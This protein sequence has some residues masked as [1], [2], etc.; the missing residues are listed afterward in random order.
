MPRRFVRWWWGLPRWIKLLKLIVILGVVLSFPAKTAYENWQYYHR[1]YD[2]YYAHFY[3]A[4]SQTHADHLAHHW[5][6]HYAV[7]YA[8]Y[9]ASP[10][11]R[12][13][14]RYALPSATP[15]TVTYPQTSPV[16][17]LTTTTRGLAL[18]KK[19]EGLRM[20]PYKDAGGKLTIGYGHLIKPGEFYAQI[21]T[22]EAEALLRND[23]RVAEAYVKRYVT[24][25]LTQAEF[26]AL[27]SL[28]Y[29]I[30]PGNFKR[31]TLLRELNAG[32]KQAAAEE[33][34]RWNRVGTRQL[35]GLSRRRAAEK[36]L[37]ESS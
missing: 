30:G 7:F 16:A 8:S 5:A 21:S 17:A 1:V 37:F 28:V 35:R 14:L 13:S 31:S 4:Y 34:L 33:F 3:A 27:T 20:E 29:N 36:A 23:I 25:P 9:Y 15:E 11:Y 19:F 12:A 22:H 6:N 18:L 24:V 10:A 32:N 26:S 2:E